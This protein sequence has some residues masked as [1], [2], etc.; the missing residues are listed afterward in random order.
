MDLKKHSKI[1]C[2]YHIVRG[3]TILYQT[4]NCRNI[5]ETVHDCVESGLFHAPSNRPKF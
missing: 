5:N 3:V 2:D 1:C 4:A